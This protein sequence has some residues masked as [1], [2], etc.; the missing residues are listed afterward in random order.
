LVNERQ[1]VLHH[2]IQQPYR[3]PDDRGDI[4]PHYI[5]G[6]KKKESEEKSKAE[7]NP[8]NHERKLSKNVSNTEL[9]LARSDV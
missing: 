4:S 6:G 8:T 3:R 7:N 1:K 5:G 2:N 9:E